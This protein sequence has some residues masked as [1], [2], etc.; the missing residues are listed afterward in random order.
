MASVVVEVVESL[1]SSPK[2]RISICRSRP[3][4]TRSSSCRTDRRALHQILLNLVGNAIKYTPAG[5]VR[6]DGSVAEDRDATLSLR[7]TDT[8]IGIKP[9]DLARLFQAFEQLDPSST[10]RRR[11]GLRLYLSRKL[12]TLI[13]GA[14]SVESAYGHGSTFILT[15]PLSESSA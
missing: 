13:G 10:R 12:A 7:V 11:P 4:R 2:P 9:D 14:L 1:R 15:I 5:T 8:G 6:I 3:L